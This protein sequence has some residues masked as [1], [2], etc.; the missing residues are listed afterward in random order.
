M[1]RLLPSVAEA[2]PVV[3]N[4]ASLVG[5]IVVNSALGFVFW[6]L[7][8]RSFDP[9]DV[10]LAAASIAAM[11]L[12]GT[13]G[14][15]GLGTLLIGELSQRQGE[16]LA[17]ITTSMAAAG[18]A[19]AVLGLAFVAVAPIIS[20][21]LAVLRSSLGIASLFAVGTGLI[22]ATLV[23][24]NALIG[25]LRGGIQLGRNALF[26][27]A[28]LL[29]LIAA[30]A[31]M[32]ASALEIF[33]AWVVGAAVALLVALWWLA[34]NASRTR[35]SL[36]PRPSLLKGL[37][38]SAVAHHTLN[39]SLQAAGQLMPLVVTAVLSAT[40][41]AYFYTASMVAYLVYIAPSSLATVFYAVGAADPSAMR[42]RLRLTI[43]LGLVAA[44]AGNLVLLVAARPVLSLFGE[45]YAREA[46]V[47]LQL[48]ALQAFTFVVR[49]H[50]VA[51]KRVE[52][53]P[54]AAAP[55][56]VIGAALKIVMASIGAKLNGLTGLAVGIIIASLIEAAW[57][58]P[59]VIR[60]ARRPA[61][62]GVSGGMAEAGD[63][64]GSE[65]ARRQ[66]VPEPVARQGGGR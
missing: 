46:L 64:D 59:T 7:A 52:A 62:A 9:A 63:V 58:A 31:F 43:G 5:S 4:S 34:V 61:N 19:G 50:Y 23:L 57:M 6:W 56:V 16:K 38:R 11:T 49:E 28:K 51:V 44:V 17:L 15:M 55:K 1:R 18:L 14:V 60:A 48:F 2:W 12:F 24:D 54:L 29:A 30:V 22:A 41:N 26:G 66:V 36:L 13:V 3:F 10:G 47:P 53:S 37:G 33:A 45:S 8:A 39:V 40:A 25:L 32:T 42:R 27:V 20:P 35:S 65:L 21:D